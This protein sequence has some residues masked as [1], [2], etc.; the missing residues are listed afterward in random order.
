MFGILQEL[1]VS[2][3]LQCT[4]YL[5]NLV[6]AEQGTSITSNFVVTGA[7]SF[8]I[9]FVKY[10]NVT[11]TWSVVIHF[12]SS[13]ISTQHFNCV[14]FCV[15]EVAKKKKKTLQTNKKTTHV[16]KENPFKKTD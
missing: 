2:S 9:E 12:P 16:S 13:A 10:V 4:L 1:P 8:I 7:E 6:T 15:G 11:E 3:V 14:E 5:G